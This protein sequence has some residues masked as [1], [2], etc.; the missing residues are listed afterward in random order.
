MRR[1]LG[2]IAAVAVL[3]TCLLS[4]TALAAGNCKLAVTVGEVAQ[5]KVSATV[6]IK[7]NPG[8]ASLTF[9]L[10]FD[11]TKLTLISASAVKTTLGTAVTLNTD[12]PGLD[13][14]TLNEVGFSWYDTNAVN[15]IGA[16]IT[17]EFKLKDGAWSNADLALAE[18]EAMDG[19]MTGLTTSTSNAGVNNPVPS[20]THTPDAAWQSD[21]NQHWHKCTDV[22]CT[23]KL[24]A[25]THTF[26][27]SSMK[28]ITPAT[29]TTHGEFTATC[30]VCGYVKS[31]QLHN[32]YIEDWVYDETQ[33]WHV[34]TVPGWGY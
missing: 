34:C 10:K 22:G 12:Q 15:G 17:L 23:E 24:D 28:I 6:S 2:L 16:L 30:K 1:A 27:Q 7:E 26:D 31:G 13:L 20:H 18:V 19:N 5:G 11:N 29:E 33:H 4:G 32:G 25:A 8:I 14:S 21:D 3:V 9:S